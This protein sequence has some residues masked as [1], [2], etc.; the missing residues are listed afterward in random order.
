MHFKLSS[1]KVSN[2]I[3]KLI[4]EL[5]IAFEKLGQPWMLASVPK[6]IYNAGC[7]TSS[8]RTRRVAL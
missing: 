6:I 8:D 5:C 7:L 1:W 4:E 2:R 3:R